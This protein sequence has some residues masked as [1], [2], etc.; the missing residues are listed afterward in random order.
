MPLV[1]DR[2]KEIVNILATCVAECA[3]CAKDCAKKGNADMATCI[4]LCN[5][6]AQLRA[7]CIPLVACGSSFS[8]G[9]MP[10]VRRRLRAV[11]GR[12]RAARHDRVRQGVP[13]GR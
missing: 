10:A 11:C 13:Q 1:D 7:A 3:A 2:T 9:T 6:C 4:A 5:D 12:V 8:A